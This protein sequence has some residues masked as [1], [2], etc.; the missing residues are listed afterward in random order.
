MMIMTDPPGVSAAGGEH[1]RRLSRACRT[2][3]LRIPVP[4]RNHTAGGFRSRAACRP[5]APWSGNARR[6]GPTLRP[7]GQRTAPDIPRP[8]Q[9]T[10]E[11]PSVSLAIRSSPRDAFPG[12]T[13]TTCT[14]TEVSFARATTSPLSRL[15]HL[16][17]PSVKTT[18][19]FAPV[20]SLPVI[21]SNHIPR[22]TTGPRSRELFTS[23]MHRPSR[24]RSVVSGQLILTTSLNRTTAKLSRRGGGDEKPPGGLF[25]ALQI[26]YPV[27]SCSNPWRERSGPVPR[28]RPMALRS[29]N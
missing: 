15:L 11:A 25:N 17:L 2:Y 19:A 29:R 9:T 24:S 7:S 10:D 4:E 3:L 6:N 27:C 23:P 22:C 21:R 13:A 26:P 28:F 14:G 20:P 1:P 18:T 5:P 12:R 16:V 8:A